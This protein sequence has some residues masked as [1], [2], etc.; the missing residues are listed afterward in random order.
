MAKLPMAP[1]H[2]DRQID[3]ENKQ[4]RLQHETNL[5]RAVLAAL[6]QPPHLF[7][8]TVRPLWNK[9]HRVNVL[10]GDDAASV[11]IAHSFFIESEESGNILSSEPRIARLYD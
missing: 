6:G 11:R 1:P 4:V 2:Q 7:S 8:V 10:V 9:F 3:N 5:Q